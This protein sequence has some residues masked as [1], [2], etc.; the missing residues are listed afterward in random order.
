MGLGLYCSLLTPQAR[1][2]L[3]YSENE[4][5][6]GMKLKSRSPGENGSSPEG[7]AAAQAAG[8]AAGQAALLRLT[9]RLWHSPPKPAMAHS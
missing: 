8:T 5:L 6:Y 9:V 3:Q 7:L 1:A 4:L 2:V